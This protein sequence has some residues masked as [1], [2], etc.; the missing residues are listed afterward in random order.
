MDHSPSL[1]KEIQFVTC[2]HY[3]FVPMDMLLDPN[4]P[5]ASDTV[6]LEGHQRQESAMDKEIGLHH[7]LQHLAGQ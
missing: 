7:L 3:T 4:G 1:L 5:S 6:L 2:P